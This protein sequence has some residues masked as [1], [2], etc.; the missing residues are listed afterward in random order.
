M[1]HTIFQF[2]SESYRFPRRSLGPSKNTYLLSEQSHEPAM[3][4][5]HFRVFSEFNACQTSIYLPCAKKWGC[6]VQQASA[7]LTLSFRQGIFTSALKQK[8]A[9]INGVK[10]TA[11]IG[12]AIL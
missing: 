5:C 10:S 2:V 12:K 9:P 11:F 6:T 7:P 1:T 4:H 3:R 8:Q